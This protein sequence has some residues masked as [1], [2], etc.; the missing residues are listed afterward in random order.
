[1]C[2]SNNKFN[3][4]SFKGFTCMENILNYQHISRKLLSRNYKSR[5]RHSKPNRHKM[6]WSKN[7]L[8][9]ILGLQ[10]NFKLGLNT[11]RLQKQSNIKLFHF[12]K[13]CSCWY[14]QSKEKTLT[15]T[16]LVTRSIYF[17]LSHFGLDRCWQNCFMKKKNIYY[18]NV[19]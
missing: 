15:I 9:S 12:N 6:C 2:V 19:N 1:M 13:V 3:I 14:F 7:N 11:L 4:Y 18:P 5:F 17:G 8:G 16:H 10:N